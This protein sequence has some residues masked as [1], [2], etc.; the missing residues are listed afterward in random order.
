M[1]CSAQASARSC[2]GSSAKQ[3]A[4]PQFSSPRLLVRVVRTIR[5]DNTV[6]AVTNLM[7]GHTAQRTVALFTAAVTIVLPGRV[8]RNHTRYCS[9]VVRTTGLGGAVVRYATAAASVVYA[10]CIITMPCE[11]FRVQ[12]GLHV[13]VNS[14]VAVASRGELAKH[15]VRAAGAERASTVW[16]LN[17][18]MLEDAVA[19]DGREPLRPDSHVVSCQ[20]QLQSERLDKP[21]IPVCYEGHLSRDLLPPHRTSKLR[22]NTTGKTQHSTALHT[23]TLLALPRSHDLSIIH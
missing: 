6:R 3:T 4:L 22:P 19:S 9:G 8:G 14:A 1:G 18:Y 17:I 12:L 2:C 21:S 16:G 13:M 7:A 5:Y 15:C 11:L 23:Y 10:T 20:V